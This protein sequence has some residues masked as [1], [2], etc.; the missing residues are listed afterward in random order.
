M[1]SLRVTLALADDRN[2]AKWRANTAQALTDSEPT[3]QPIDISSIFLALPEH[4]T[5][6]WPL[7]LHNQ[8]KDMKVGK[9]S[10]EKSRRRKHT[11]PER[12]QANCRTEQHHRPCNIR[13]AA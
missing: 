11:P 7:P 13:D 4:V 10:A 9:H 6:C 12:T 3:E 2:V 5:L 8:D 1:G